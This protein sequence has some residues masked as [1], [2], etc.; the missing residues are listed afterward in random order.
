M[1]VLE[2]VAVVDCD[3][4]LWHPMGVRQKLERYKAEG[5]AFPSPSNIQMISHD[6]PQYT[7]ECS[8]IKSHTQGYIDKSF[9]GVKR[10][11]FDTTLKKN[12]SFKEFGYRVPD[13]NTRDDEPIIDRLKVLHYAK[14]GYDHYVDRTRFKGSRVSDHNKQF[15][16]SYHYAQDF[17]ITLNEFN[18]FFNHPGFVSDIHNQSTYPPFVFSPHEVRERPKNSLLS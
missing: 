6:Y 14:L 4:F 8:L 1:D 5:I 13:E 7:D 16:L 12:Y 11:A 17:N 15:G 10:L 3:E 2:W 9:E 18:S